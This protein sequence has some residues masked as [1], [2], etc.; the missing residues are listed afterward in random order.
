MPLPPKQAGPDFEELHPQQ[1]LIR[2]PLV[3]PLIKSEGTITGSRFM[4]T[5]WRREGMLARLRN[6]GFSV[7]T[8]ENQ[9][10]ALP[11]LPPARMIGDS[12]FRPI[13][14][15]ERYSVFDPQ[16]LNWNA[17]TPP[18]DDP[19]R[20]CLH[21]N[22]IIRKRRGRGASSYYRVF[23]EHSGTA[24]I[25]PLTETDALLQGYAQAAQIT[26]LPLHVRSINERYH[27]PPIPLPPPYRA[28]LRRL[29]TE[30]DNSWQTDEHGWPLT[31]HL[32]ERLGV[33][34]STGTP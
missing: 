6:A 32:Y 31:R 24:G 17:A 15:N 16:A 19:S 14:H 13:G 30:T 25:T 22:E 10:D 8:L 29:A 7:L 33:E 1:F 27:I 34:L 12:C 4:L 28:M 20:V 11:P 21:V 18:P 9:I 3:R 23:P 5:S 2:N 26:R